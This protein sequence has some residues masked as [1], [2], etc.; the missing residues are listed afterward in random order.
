[1][2]VSGAYLL[3]LEAVVVIYIY[4]FHHLLTPLVV[5]MWMFTQNMSNEQFVKYQKLLGFSMGAFAYVLLYMLV[6]RRA[7][8]T[9]KSS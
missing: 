9:T 6:I 1:M 4:Y 2:H 3:V 5:G 7:Y 8:N